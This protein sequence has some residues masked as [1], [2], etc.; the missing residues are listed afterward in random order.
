MGI[1]D[2]GQGESRPY[3]DVGVGFIRPGPGLMN[4]APTDLKVDYV[5]VRFIEPGH[6][7]SMPNKFP[8][9][10]SIR[11]KH[12]SYKSDGYYFVTIC[13]AD[14][15]PLINRYREIVEGVLL[16]LPIRFTG[17]ALDYYKL[18][19]DH[20]HLILIFQ[21]VRA[22]LGEIIRTFKAMVKHESRVREF[23]QRNYYEH[24]IRNEK[25]LSKIREYIQ[26]NPM[27]ERI[28]FEEFYK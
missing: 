28:R 11:L 4:Q 23:W 5:G 20:I 25:A 2:S 13:T 26:N 1:Q 16:S 19:D 14:K 3:C 21:E 15:R 24:V 9:R 22:S 18:M 10:K 12:Y 17:L 7:L 27:A 8:Q 6:R